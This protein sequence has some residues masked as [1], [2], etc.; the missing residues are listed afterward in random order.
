MRKGTDSGGKRGRNQQDLG[1]LLWEVRE[2][3]P[4]ATVLTGDSFAPRAHLATSGD[5]FGCHNL[6]GHA[7]GI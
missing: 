6:G 2:R 1:H 5:R 4:K 3:Q 7:V